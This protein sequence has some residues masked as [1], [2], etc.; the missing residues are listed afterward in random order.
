MK[1]MPQTDLPPVSCAEFK[2]V[3]RRL[4]A[5]VT[6]ITSADGEKKLGMTA[7]AVCSVSSDPPTVLIVVNKSNRSYPIIAQTRMFAVN[8]L[9]LDQEHVASHFSS[10]PA[11]PFA[12]IPHTIRTT[13]CPIVERAD[14]YMECAV[15][16][17][18]DVGTHTIFVGKIVSAD[19]SGREPLLYHESRY[20]GLESEERARHGRS[21]S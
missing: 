20:V 6:I 3:M 5:S 9:S 13:G 14:A 8:V 2:S 17:Q 18:M 21:V 4:A 12:E 16:Q 10:K 11:D 7:T 1:L 19:A 15:I